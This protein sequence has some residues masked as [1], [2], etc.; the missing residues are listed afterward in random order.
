MSVIID[1]V[2]L[3]IEETPFIADYRSGPDAIPILCNLI[4]VYIE[5][6]KYTVYLRKKDGALFIDH[7]Y[8]YKDKEVT[9]AH[10]KLIN[11]YF[12]LRKVAD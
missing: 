3:I 9:I 8:T 5:N 2:E 1:G 7:T 12:K 4:Y 10:I 6:M 11:Y